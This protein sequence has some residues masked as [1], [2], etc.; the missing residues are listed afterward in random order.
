MAGDRVIHGRVQ[1]CSP[2]ANGV[3]AGGSQMS[4]CSFDGGFRVERAETTIH[5]TSRG[6]CTGSLDSCYLTSP[7]HQ[8]T[9]VYGWIYIPHQSVD[10]PLRTASVSPH[11]LRSRKLKGLVPFLFYL[12]CHCQRLPNRR[13]IASIQ[14]SLSVLF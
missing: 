11:P 7:L 4:S 14:L 6:M 10:P 12:L 3:K 8:T 5:R 1:T 13:S 2:G 9:R